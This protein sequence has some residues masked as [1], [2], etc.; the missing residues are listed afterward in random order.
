MRLAA[1]FVEPGHGAG[2]DSSLKPV[3]QYQVGP[4][5]PLSDKARHLREIV[6]VVGIAHDDELAFGFFDSLLQ[7][8]AVASGRNMYN[9]GTEVLRD[10]YR[11]IGRAIV[12]NYNFT[13]KSH[14]PKRRQCLVHANTDRAGF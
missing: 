1:S 12:G 4:F 10:F 2:L 7:G 6:A 13:A 3:A 8:I 5:A 9:A 11:A 14:F